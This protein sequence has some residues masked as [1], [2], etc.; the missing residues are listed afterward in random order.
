MSIYF[1][2]NLDNEL[3]KIGYSKNYERRVKDIKSWGNKNLKV[4][5]VIEGDKNLEKK[6]QQH[7]MNYQIE[8]EWFKGSPEVKK[9]ISK[10]KNGHDVKDLFDN[11]KYE[12]VHLVAQIPKELDEE[13]RKEIGERYGYIR[14]GIQRATIEAIRMWINN[15]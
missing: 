10:L 9:F 15:K 8:R 5:C 3:I 13:F 4:L 7:F 11:I 12:P 14:G 6:I 2:K 1:I